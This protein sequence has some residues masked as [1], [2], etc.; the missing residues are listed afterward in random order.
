[1]AKVDLIVIFLLSSNFHYTFLLIPHIPIC[2]ILEKKNHDLKNEFTKEMILK[3][4]FSRYNKSISTKKLQTK[5]NS[6][7]KVK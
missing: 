1:M 5:K 6:F 2:I 4:W 3:I 7:R